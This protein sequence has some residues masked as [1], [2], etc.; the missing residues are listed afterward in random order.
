M[1]NRLARAAGLVAFFSSIPVV[2]G[3]MLLIK[4]Y[5]DHDESIR[6]GARWE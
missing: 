4:S 3:A 1:R 2:V 5:K 6:N